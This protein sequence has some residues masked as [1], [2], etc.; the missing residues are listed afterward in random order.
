MHSLI[1]RNRVLLLHLSFWCVHLSFFVYQ[2]ISHQ[3]TPDIDWSLVLTV[4]G[5]QVIFSL[6]IAYFHYFVLLPQFLKDKRL[7]RYLFQFFITFAILITLR[8]ALG[9]YLIE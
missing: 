4:V 2:V 7:G 9:R 1:H 8:V 3:R 5:V 6:I